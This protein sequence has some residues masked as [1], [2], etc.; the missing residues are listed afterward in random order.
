MA[1]GD[2]IDQIVRNIGQSPRDST[3][4]NTFY[5]L[6][7]TGR[8]AAIPV[9]TENHGYTF[10]TRPLMNMSYNNLAIDRVLSNLLTEEPQ[11]IQRMVRA[12][13]DPRHIKLDRG[14]FDAPG[15][16]P[17][18]PFIPL[19]S[20]NLISMSGWPDFTINTH[21]SQPG[22][23]REE[24]SYVDD[25]PYEYRTFDLQTS[26]RNLAGDPISFM[27]LMWGWYMGLVYE[28]R[29]MPYPDLVMKNEIDYNTRIYRLVMDPSKT[30]I[31]R[32]GATGAS[33]PMTAPI[34]TI[35]NHEGDGAETPFETAT[36]Q[37]TCS[38]RCMGFTY[39]D[40]ILIYEFNALTEMFNIDMEEGRRERAM[41]K[42]QPQEKYFFNYSAYPR[43]NEFTMEL[44]WWVYKDLY[45]REAVGIFGSTAT[46]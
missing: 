22:L 1:I 18:N 15:I 14:N 23:Y 30:F 13:L 45:Q 32:I 38:W 40:T 20:N 28:G 44:E 5:G 35:F 8:N 6:N 39:Y 31:T 46:T 34:G 43:I 21:T 3:I 42:L 16:D 37:I 41:V 9:N 19:L 29:I 4:S 7:V 10:F 12:Y 26:F 11:S 36:N 2:Y 25:V 17:K 33:F 27:L 24:Y